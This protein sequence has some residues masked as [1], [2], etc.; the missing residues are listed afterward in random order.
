M[1]KEEAQ[2]S[3]KFKELVFFIDTNIHSIHPLTDKEVM[4]EKEFMMVSNRFNLG[5]YRAEMLYRAKLY[6]VPYTI[7]TVSGADRYAPD[8]K[9]DT[10]Y[11]V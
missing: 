9:V 6:K 8:L 5:E 7:K 2:S 4:F 10:I 1:E 3:Y 11:P